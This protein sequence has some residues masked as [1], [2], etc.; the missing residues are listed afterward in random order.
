MGEKRTE[1][2]KRL[3]RINVKSSA[4]VLA[5]ENDSKSAFESLKKTKHL[6][7]ELNELVKINS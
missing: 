4:T 7:H 6:S 2:S 3:S 1:I 5:E